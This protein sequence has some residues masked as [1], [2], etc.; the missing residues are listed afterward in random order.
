[1]SK[2]NLTELTVEELEAALASKKQIDQEAE[3]KE[4]S[5]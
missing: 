4:N 5:N 1:M 3:E 2:I